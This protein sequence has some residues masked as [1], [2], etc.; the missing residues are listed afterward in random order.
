[1]IHRRA[2]VGLLMGA[3][4]VFARP[5]ALLSQAIEHALHV[6]VVDRSGATAQGTLIADPRRPS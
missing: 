6:T 1:V 3:A 2:I 5:S 4:L